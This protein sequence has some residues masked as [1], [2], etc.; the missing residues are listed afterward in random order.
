[1]TVLV[2]EATRVRRPR[3]A[4]AALDDEAPVAPVDVHHVDAASVV[5]A[6]RE[7]ERNSPP[8]GRREWP[9]VPAFVPRQVP[10]PADADSCG[11]DLGFARDGPVA[12][13]DDQA[14]AAG[15]RL[16]RALRGR[17]D[18]GERGDD[19]GECEEAHDRDGSAVS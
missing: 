3:G 4:L 6:A 18:E 10:R 11:V 5:T 9:R 8:I 15:V 12:R 2:G 16:A 7:V 14:V 1:M 17:G 19:D 13:E